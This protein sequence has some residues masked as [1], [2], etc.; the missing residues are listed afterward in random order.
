LD[1]VVGAD[2]SVRPWFP[3]PT[4]IG[5]GWLRDDCHRPLHIYGQ[6]DINSHGRP[7]VAPT[8]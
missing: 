5:L 7:M 3:N 2:A 4:L 8:E 1:I 6:C